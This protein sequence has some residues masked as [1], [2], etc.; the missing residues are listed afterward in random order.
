MQILTFK[1]QAG[2]NHV[3]KHRKAS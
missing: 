2:S 1:L 3:L